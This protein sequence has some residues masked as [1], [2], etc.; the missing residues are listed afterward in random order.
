MKQL[1]QI[2]TVLLLIT[3]LN[4]CTSISYYT[5]AISGHLALTMAGKPVDSYIAS[6]ETPDGLRNKLIVS[7]QARHFATERL[8]LPTGNAFKDYVALDHSWVVVNLV[9][10]PEFSLQAHQWCYP[11]LG[12]QAYRGYFH[13]EDAE[14]EEQRFQA[15]GYDTFIGGVTAYSTL[16]WFD[17]PLHSG[18]TNLSDDRMVALMFHELAHQVVYIKEDTGFNE[19]FATAVELEG[20]KLWLAHQGEPSV[21]EQALVRFE[22]RNKTYA[23]VESASVDL[24]NLYRQQGILSDSR[25]RKRKRLIFE[26]LNAS[27]EGLLDDENQRTESRGNREEIKGPFGTPPVAFNNA[28]IALFKQYNQYVPAFRQLL[29]QSDYD[30]PTFYRAVKSLSRQP[31]GQRQQM[32]QDL[33]ERF[34]EHF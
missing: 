18:F 11:V 15:K 31:D 26:E 27:Y 17:D 13:L 30:F 21:F 33:S 10:V 12:C 8:D 3:C 9:A 6:H 25:L 4:G 20:L 34:K 7:R 19:S 28:R 32:L 23:L 5:Q 2:Y 16:G 14:L 1:S 29:K 24:K 22:L